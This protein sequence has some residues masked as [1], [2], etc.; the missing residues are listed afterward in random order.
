MSIA[1]SLTAAAS[2]LWPAM[3]PMGESLNYIER[4][5]ATRTAESTLTA[6]EEARLLRVLAGALMLTQGPR[7]S[8]RKYPTEALAIA[9]RMDD[10]N[11]RVQALLS[12]SIQ[13]LYAGN[14]REAATLAENCSAAGASSADAGH[15]LMGAGVAAPA[16]FCLGEFASAQRYIDSILLQDQSSSQYWF[17][18]YRLGAQCTLSNLQWLRGF[19][20]QAARLAESAVEQSKTSGSAIIRMDVLA[21]SAVPI[22]FYV[23]DLVAAEHGI[24]TLLDLSAKNALWVWHAR[25]RCLRGMLLLARGD[26][27]GLPLLES[28]LEWLREANFFYLYTMSAAALAQGLGEAG[29]TVRARAAIEHAN[30]KE[31]YWCIAELLR[32]KGEICRLD[33]GADAAPEAQD[34][35][36]RALDWARRYEALSWEL[37]AAASLAKLWRQGGQTEAAYVL[38][39]AVYDRFTEG[40]ETGD[41]R[42]AR[43]LIEEFRGV[44]AAS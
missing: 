5:L 25:G 11:G 17:L 3:A 34:C 13:S 24:T 9:E 32:I 19:P 44:L 40:F 43:T 12:L 4:A 27:S 20:E 28:A 42:M 15:R 26:R 8:F 2:A 21:Q 30:R 14:Y 38:L 1:V 37:R 29:Q 6:R 10:L 22:A 41:L 39:S 18:G 36:L 35:F 23:G 33:A 7:E 16:F 31:E